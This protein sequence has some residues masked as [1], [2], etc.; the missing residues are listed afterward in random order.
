MQTAKAVANVSS[1][2]DLVH[3]CLLSIINA[4]TH[5]IVFQPSSL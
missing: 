3:S 1:K 5:E 4:D 2:L